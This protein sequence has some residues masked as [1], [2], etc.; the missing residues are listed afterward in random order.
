MKIISGG[1][2][3]VDRAALDIAIELGLAHGG[4]VPEGRIAEDGP[5]EEK[6]ILDEELDVS[7]ATRTISNIRNSDATLII[8]RGSMIG[9]TKLTW[10]EANRSGKPVLAIDLSNCSLADNIS[11]IQNWMTRVDPGI[12]NIAGP[13]ESEAAIY[14]DSKDVL[15]KSLL[16]GTVSDI[17][18]VM[19]EQAY[20]NFRHWDQIRWLVP[21]WFV[22]VTAGTYAVLATGII[23][24][25]YPLFGFLGLAIFAFL[26]F[27]LMFNLVRYHNNQIDELLLFVGGLPIRQDLKK[28]LA[29]GLPFS[30]H[31]FK[32]LMTATCWFMIFICLVGL[33][34]LFGSV[35]LLFGP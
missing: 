1:Q 19:F 8:T 16:N 7:Y 4:W 3:G 28:E 5:I 11:R 25:P 22:T 10:E 20:A 23:H 21:Y 6:Y 29:R 18:R 2:T 14:S 34:C 13:R 30:F 31:G 15:A 24:D 26:C 33:G 27:F 35:R 32:F 17:E 9:G 12:L